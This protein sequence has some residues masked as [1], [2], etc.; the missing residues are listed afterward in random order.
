MNI[1]QYP[2]AK[3]LDVIVAAC[4]ISLALIVACAVAA[5]IWIVI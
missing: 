2:T 1:D 4:G 5:L 3:Q